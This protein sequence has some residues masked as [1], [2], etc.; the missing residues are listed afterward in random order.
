MEIKTFTVGVLATNCYVVSCL[1]TKK[2]IIIDPGLGSASEASKIIQFTKKNNLEMEYIVNTHGHSDHI[3]GNLVLKKKFDVPI[4]INSYDAYFL[5]RLDGNVEKPILLGDQ[6]EVKFG[7]TT[8]KVLHT[9]GHTLGSISLV[10]KA[11]VFTG[12]TLFAG[13]IGR[14]DFPESSENEMKLSLRKLMK[15][16]DNFIIYPGHGPQS[17]IIQERHFNPFLKYFN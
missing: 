9:P 7:R 3:S 12:D 1:E 13:G 6:R 4:C 10:G 5:D 11:Q 2:S 17:S 16:P 14:T 8:L 15:L